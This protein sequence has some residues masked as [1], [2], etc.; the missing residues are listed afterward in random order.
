MCI[1]DRDEFVGTDSV[2][3]PLALRKVPRRI[4]VGAIRGGK[5]VLLSKETVL[6][7]RGHRALRHGLKCRK[8]R[9]LRVDLVGKVNALRAENLLLPI[10]KLCHECD[11]Q[12]SR[13]LGARIVFSIPAGF[14]RC[15]EYLKEFWKGAKVPATHQQNERPLELATSMRAAKASMALEGRNV[16]KNYVRSAITEQVLQRLRSDRS[17]V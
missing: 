3:K 4:N 7:N 1:R 14:E 13:A 6:C 11:Y 15:L 17:W 5:G 9:D 16:P 12:T 10:S 2:H 8:V